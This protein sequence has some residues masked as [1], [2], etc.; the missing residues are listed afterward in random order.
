MHSSINAR[1][2][3]DTWN[4]WN[5][6]IHGANGNV[7]HKITWLQQFVE[8]FYYVKYYVKNCDVVC[9]LDNMYFDYE[10]MKIYQKVSK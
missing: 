8:H 10:S 1:V 9:F 3:V 5:L 4:T 6:L 2:V 7:H